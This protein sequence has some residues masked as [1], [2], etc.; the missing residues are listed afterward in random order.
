VEYP[1]RRF[2]R[3]KGRKQGL[4]IQRKSVMLMALAIDTMRIKGDKVAN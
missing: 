4:N 1:L 2:T 3:Q